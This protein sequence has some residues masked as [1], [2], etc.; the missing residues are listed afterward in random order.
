MEEI[1]H[2]YHGKAPAASS[3]K[4]PGGKTLSTAAASIF[5]FLNFLPLWRVHL[6]LPWLH[7]LFH[8]NPAETA[9]SPILL[10]VQGPWSPLSWP[11]AGQISGVQ[12]R[13]RLFRKYFS[14]KLRGKPKN[15]NYKR[16]E[17]DD[18]QHR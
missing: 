14:R 5:F 18:G 4:G 16:R 15:L 9:A 2:P 8:A 3:W 12:T 7:Q 11:K 10:N 17:T 13:L 6:S 1:S